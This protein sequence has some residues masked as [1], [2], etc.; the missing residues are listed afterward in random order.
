MLITISGLPGSGTTTTARLVRKDLDLE[1]VTAGMIFRNLAVERNMTLQEFSEY[2]EEHPEVDWELDRRMV[3]RGKEGDVILEGRLT[4]W[5][6][7]REGLEALKVWLTAPEEIRAERVAQ[8]E[9]ITKDQALEANRDR[10]ESERTRYQDIYDID[11]TDR[12]VYDLEVNTHKNDPDEVA[13][14][15]VEAAEERYDE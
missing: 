6:A 1:H 9:G 15:V 4:A 8:R 14:R 3:N 10:E 11:L 5:M 7:E 12:S 2:A 13:E